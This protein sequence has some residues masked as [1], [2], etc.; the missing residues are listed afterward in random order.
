[1]INIITQSA[2]QQLLICRFNQVI[3][4]QLFK[5]NYILNFFN[6]KSMIYDIWTSNLNTIIFFWIRNK[7]DFCFD[8]CLISVIEIYIRINCDT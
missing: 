5:L 4:I 3:I 6:F 7:N 8:I 2:K 1:M